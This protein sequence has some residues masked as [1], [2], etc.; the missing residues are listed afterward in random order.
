MSRKFKIGIVGLLVL[1][2]LVIMASSTVLA[3]DET[4]DKAEPEA[5]GWHGRGHG[6]GRGMLGGA[7]LEAIAEELGMTADELSTQLWGG[8]TLAD[9]AEQAGVEL[10]DLQAAASAAQEAATRE[11]IEQ[12]VEDGELTRE[13]ADWLLEGLDNGYWGGRGFGGCGR[14]GFHGRGGFG[15]SQFDRSQGGRSGRFQRPAFSSSDSDL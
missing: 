6:L 8:K 7:Q 11:A 10:E 14:M 4:P 13:H 12:A 1:S 2:L 3:Q 5:P 15:E 9:L